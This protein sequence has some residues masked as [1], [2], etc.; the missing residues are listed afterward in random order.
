MLVSISLYLNLENKRVVKRICIQKSL[1]KID[2]YYL[3]WKQLV[4]ILRMKT[5]CLY[6]YWSLI[7]I[8]CCRGNKQWL[9]GAPELDF[10]TFVNLRNLRIILP[11]FNSSFLFTVLHKCHKL[12]TLVIQNQ[13]VCMLSFQ[14]QFVWVFF[15]ASYLRASG[16]AAGRNQNQK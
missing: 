1:T 10:P 14:V 2:C 3:D 12:Q 5:T 9:L 16:G 6:S 4:F 15:D 8:C 13:K 7:L 11:C